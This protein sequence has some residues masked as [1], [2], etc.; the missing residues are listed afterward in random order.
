MQIGKRYVVYFFSC[1]LQKAGF[2]DI[3]GTTDVPTHPYHYTIA[4]LA[5]FDGYG[6]VVIALLGMFTGGDFLT[7]LTQSMG[8]NNTMAQSESRLLRQLAQ[9]FFHAF[10]LAFGDQTTAIADK[11]R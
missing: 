5:F 6:M 8:F 11:Q 4:A 3:T 10:R 9:R 2:S 7:I 1:Q